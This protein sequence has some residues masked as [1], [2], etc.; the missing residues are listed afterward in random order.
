MNHRPP[1]SLMTLLEQ[2]QR[3]NY[4]YLSTGTSLSPPPTSLVTT[5]AATGTVL[6]RHEAM[7][8]NLRCIG[9]INTVS[10]STSKTSYGI[11]RRNSSNM[12]NYYH[13]FNRRQLQHALQQ[14]LPFTK[15][16]FSSNQLLG[17][18]PM[19][20]NSNNSIMN[21]GGSGAHMGI[22][23]PDSTYIPTAYEAVIGNVWQASTWR[24]DKLLELKGE[25]NTLPEVLANKDE[26]V[27]L[28][29]L[30][31]ER[32]TLDLYLVDGI[33]LIIQ[34]VEQGIPL[35]SPT[36]TID[37]DT[38]ASLQSSG[39]PTSVILSDI[40]QRMEQKIVA[41]MEDA[42]N[43]SSSTSSI[44]HPFLSEPEWNRIL[45]W[46]QKDIEAVLSTTTTIQPAN[47]HHHVRDFQNL[48]DDPHKKL[49][50]NDDFVSFLEEQRV[51]SKS[52]TSGHD[53]SIDSATKA[54]RVLVD[55][56]QH[57][58]M[59][60]LY[61]GVVR[62]QLLL[63]LAVTYQLQQSWKILTTMTDQDIDRAAATLQPTD[64]ATSSSESV[65]VSLPSS[66]S[67]SI[68]VKKLMEVIKAY[69]LIPN[70][71]DTTQES[72]PSMNDRRMDALW[73][74][75]DKDN[76]GMID[77]VEMNQICTIA[78]SATQNAIR[79]YVKEVIEV[80]PL[81]HQPL[82]NNDGNVDA[83]KT[84]ATIKKIGW[85]QRRRIRNEKAAFLKRLNYVLQNHF[86]NELEM[87]HRLR[88]IYSWSNKKHQNNKINSIL[89]QEE[90]NG[91]ITNVVGRKR[92]VELY[93]KIAIQEFR[94]VQR[95]HFPQL[96]GIG[97]E[98]MKSLR[99]EFWIEQG[100]GRQNR[101]LQ[102]D[103]TLFLVGVC[104]L[105]Y[106]VLSL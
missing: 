22:A 89:V 72:N 20:H 56:L 44:D 30:A 86:D 19:A 70:S 38:D 46:L 98:Y 67:T 28:D 4:R 43:S 83:T 66:V 71:N 5:V 63:T 78:V 25:L 52:V 82:S 57:P 26:K 85:R 74:L 42:A 80:V 36:P 16:C 24:R 68:P 33:H 7:M 64:A 48:V 10:S 8:T 96:D 60:C 59:E 103:C 58:H 18:S 27:T 92:Y 77:Q 81:D 32:Q 75:M 14:Q 29:F 65:P 1:K 100:K 51:T 97:Q 62:Y 15:R 88:C 17:H 104:I 73:A 35:S 54:S 94:E 34:H 11:F 79:Q 37:S 41:E 55:A 102:R 93:P 50:E 53:T 105:D 101:E 76:D 21:P 87:S 23:I 6:Q 2:F 49:L 99:E 69:L 12:N 31:T 9:S 91:I 106:I 40:V 45:L 3:C 84:T 95:I 13:T 47:I 39:S 90:N 61:D